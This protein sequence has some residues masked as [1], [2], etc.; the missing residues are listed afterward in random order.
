MVDQFHSGK[1]V[2]KV[3][4]AQLA[5]HLGLG[6]IHS[7][8][9]AKLE[10]SPAASMPELDVDA[11]STLLAR[12]GVAPEDAAEV[13]RT[14]P[15]AE[16]DPELWRLLELSCHIL[17]NGLANQ[18][19][20]AEPLPP[21]PATLSLFPV[22]AILGAMEAIRQRHQELGIPDDVSWETLSY[23][24]RAMTSYRENHGETGIH[25]SRWD[26]MRFSCRLYQVGRLTVIP[27]RLCTHPEAGPLFWYDDETTTRLGPGFRKGD[28]ALSLHIPSTDPLTPEACDDSLR[29]MRTAFKGVYAGE[30]LRVATCTSWLLDEQLA[31]YLPADSNILAFQRR[32][33]MI[34][35]ARDDDAILRFLFGA[36]RPKEIEALPQRTTLERAVVRHLQLGRNWRLRT[37]WVEL[38][39]S[40]AD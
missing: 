21:L 5:K 10:T 40:G 14:M 12:L 19:E 39:T 7:A 34:P 27:Y 1:P 29:R 18:G 8:W 6:D 24:G 26:W 37:G 23:L 35:G 13:L 4:M 28:P 22:H 33:N 20:G 38:G 36:E 16:R 2:A 9:L 25:I 11:L 31:E 30:S 3:T 17:T 15:S 32:F